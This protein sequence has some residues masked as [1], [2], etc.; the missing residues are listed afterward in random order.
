M[1]REL[2]AC[3]ISHVYPDGAVSPPDRCTSNIRDEAGRSP[4]PVP[5]PS[6][7]AGIRMTEAHVRTRPVRRCQSGPEPCPDAKAGPKSLPNG[8]WPSPSMPRDSCGRPG[9]RSPR[10]SLQ[11]LSV[12]PARVNPAFLPPG[13]S[14]Y[15]LA[16]GAR[17]P[18]C[19]KF[20]KLE[21][22]RI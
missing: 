19:P 21:L 7:H 18:H 14:G 5:E 20:I 1:A 12:C 16:P 17:K 22:F 10:T 3:P 8:A 13:T 4:E 2:L 6:A 9:I 11:A 15:L